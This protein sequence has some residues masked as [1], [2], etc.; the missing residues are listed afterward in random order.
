MLH[1]RIAVLLTRSNELSLVEAFWIRME[2][3]IYNNKKPHSDCPSFFDFGFLLYSRGLHV[4]LHPLTFPGLIY[5]NVYEIFYCASKLIYTIF[6][7]RLRM[8]IRYPPLFPSSRSSPFLFSCFYPPV[9]PKMHASTKYWCHC[10]T[11]RI[12][13]WNLGVNMSSL[14][15]RVLQKHT[16]RDRHTIYLF[17]IIFT[18]FSKKKMVLMNIEWTSV[19]IKLLTV[20][21][22]LFAVQSTSL[23]Y[24]FNLYINA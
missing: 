15:N 8:W 2:N 1:A 20:I 7:W 16:Y 12:F 23:K 11:L 19:Y 3:I 17:Y 22:F 18:T 24:E 5:N 13:N 14:Y 10:R 9:I 21:F 4:H 6:S